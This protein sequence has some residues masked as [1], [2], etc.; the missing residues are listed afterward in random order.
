[1]EKTLPYG[2]W[3]LSLLFIQF[4]LEDFFFTEKNRE[5]EQLEESFNKKVK[6]DNR[7]FLLREETE[8]GTRQ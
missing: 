7:R 6:R 4:Q 2:Q 8:R 3:I 5:K 1:M